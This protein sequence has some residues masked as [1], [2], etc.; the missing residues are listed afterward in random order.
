[1]IG[2]GVPNA[3]TVLSEF[4][5]SLAQITAF[6]TAKGIPVVLINQETSIIEKG[7]HDIVAQALKLGCSHVLFLDSDMIFPMNVLEALLDAK[8]TIVGANYSTRTEPTRPTAK[9]LNDKDISWNT[10][11]REVSKLATGCLLVDLQ[12]FEDIGKPYFAVEWSDEL[13][14]FVGE[15]YN[16]CVRVNLAG[17]KVFCD[18]DLSRE[19]VHVGKQGHA[20]S[21]EEPQIIKP[22]LELVS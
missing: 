15:D 19:I 13:N 3:G 6:S 21:Q 1:M 22:Q 20:L 9:D 16:F 18:H 7:R 14:D 10:G 5:M 12:V 2:I 17:Y 8:K 4:A 11:V